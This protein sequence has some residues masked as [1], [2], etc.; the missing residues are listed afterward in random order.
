MN[1][2]NK[3]TYTPEEYLELKGSLDI[4]KEPYYSDL[5]L[6]PNSSNH[7]ELISNNLVQLFSQHL[8][9]PQNETEEALAYHLYYNGVRF[10]AI[11][12][13]FYPSPDIFITQTPADEALIGF[14]KDPVM[15]GEVLSKMT[16]EFDHH[17]KLKKYINLPSL[18]Y[19]LLVTQYTFRIELYTRYEDSDQ[20]TYQS[21]D[22]PDSMVSIPALKFEAS[23]QEIYQGTNITPKKFP[24]VKSK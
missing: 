9:T 8:P 24:F 11:K 21:I 14:K 22:S 1:A 16:D 2:S 5:F 3:S 13:R 12:D 4:K 7:H 23:A 17:F 18:K 19:Y 15:I 10:E 20:W 6:Y